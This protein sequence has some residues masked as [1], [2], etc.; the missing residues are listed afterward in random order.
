M[1]YL[2]IVSRDQRATTATRRRRMND[3]LG[4]LRFA[5]STLAADDDALVAMVPQKAA[6][7]LTQTKRLLAKCSTHLRKALS[8][9]VKR[10]G[11][12]RDPS[13]ARA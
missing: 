13:G 10:C 7:V 12:S 1:T 3:A 6:Q 11:A 8:A 2:N 9:S 5:T 4:A